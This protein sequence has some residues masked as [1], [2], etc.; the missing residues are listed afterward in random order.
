MKRVRLCGGPFK[1]RM[2]DLEDGM[3]TYTVRDAL[4]NPKWTTEATYV[5]CEPPRKGADGI[6]LWRISPVHATYEHAPRT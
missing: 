3:K 2:I 1:D 4:T 6:E 5:Q